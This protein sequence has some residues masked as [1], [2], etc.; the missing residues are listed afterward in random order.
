VSP[1]FFRHTFPNTEADAPG[2]IG[3]TG[4]FLTILLGAAVRVF[5]S[6]HTYIINPDGIYYIH[7]AKA[8]Y[9][10]EWDAL[11]SCHINFVSIY[12]FLI[13]A[14]YVLFLEWIMAA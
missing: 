8:I 14:G 5:A 10:A 6:L 13:S 9:F 3:T 11:T 7:Q 2:R 12:P 4:V 1:S